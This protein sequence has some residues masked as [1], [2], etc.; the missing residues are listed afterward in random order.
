[1]FLNEQSAPSGV[2]ERLSTVYLT[3]I[4][5]VGE[6]QSFGLSAGTGTWFFTREDILS[7]FPLSISPHTLSAPLGRDIPNNIQDQSCVEDPVSIQRTGRSSSPR[8]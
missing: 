7:Y 6:K 1:M 4:Y 3:C 5:L 2:L 8:R